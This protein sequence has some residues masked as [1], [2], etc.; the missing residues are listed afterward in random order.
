M[1][2]QI[3]RQVIN[4][5]ASQ[6]KAVT[7]LVNKYDDAVYLKEVAPG[8]NRAIYIF[9]HLIAAS[10][11]LLPLFGLGDKLFPQLADLFSA[12]PDRT[13]ADIPSIA[14]LRQAWETVNS[15]LTEHFNTMQP[16]DWLSRH[17]KVSEE[18]FAIDP[19]RNKLNVLIGRTVHEGYHLGQLNFLTV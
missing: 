7:A 18:D 12:N 17:T 3:I 5:W 4:A 1:K 6:N 11:N 16:P 8:R 14:E 10:D 19:L 15:T 2:E 13:F 9:G